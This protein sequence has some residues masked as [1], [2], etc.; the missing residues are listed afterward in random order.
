MLAC[1][2]RYVLFPGA[3]VATCTS[4]YV[5]SN[6][7]ALLTCDIRVHVQRFMIPRLP[8][9]FQHFSVRFLKQRSTCTVTEVAGSLLDRVASRV[10]QYRTIRHRVQVYPVNFN[11]TPYTDTDKTKLRLFNECALILRSISSFCT[12]QYLDTC[13]H[14]DISSVSSFHM[15]P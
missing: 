9:S 8:I 15:L 11:Y 3:R 12:R 2:Y 14:I 7:T 4:K 6:S 10:F 5:T 13:I 1:I